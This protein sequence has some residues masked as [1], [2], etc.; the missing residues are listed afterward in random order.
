MLIVILKQDGKSA[1]S[2]PNSKDKSF[3]NLCILQLIKLIK[4][5]LV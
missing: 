4:R 2:N 3:F 5:V 1:K